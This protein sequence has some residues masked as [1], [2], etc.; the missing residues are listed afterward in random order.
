M[1]LRQYIKATGAAVTGSLLAGCAASGSNDAASEGDANDD[2]EGSGSGESGTGT[3][4]TSVTDQPVDIDDF[5]SCVVTIDGIWVKPGNGEADEAP[6]PDGDDRDE[7][8]T[9]TQGTEETAA[10]TG[11]GTEDASDDLEDEEDA[12]GD[13]PNEG[14]EDA[15]AAEEE[16]RRYVEFD[17][18]QEADLVRLQG[19]NTQLIDETELP[20]GEYR[21]LQLEVSGV[22]GVL[23]EGGEAEVDVPG[24]APLQFKERFEIRPNERTRFVADF[25]PVRRGQGD[26]Y[27]LRPVATGTR[28]LYGDEEYDPSAGGENGRDD[29]TDENDADDANG[30]N[31]DEREADGNRPDADEGSDVPDES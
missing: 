9:D 30:E 11:S 4:A 29:D 22:A 8:G 23:V 28:V 31:V 25:A 27:L 19:A 13:G 18:P 10:E 5:E 16:G 26:R 7:A 2:V 6:N 17:Q 14:V 24:N 20:V 12:E 3:L 21:Y 1:K 15:A